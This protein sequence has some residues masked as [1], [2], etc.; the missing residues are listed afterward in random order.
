[1]LNSEK[2]SRRMLLSVAV[3]AASALLV[4][5]A[6]HAGS[7]PQKAVG[8][9]TSPNDGKQCSLCK[10]FIAGDKPDGPGT[11]KSVAGEIVPNGWCKL[12]AAKDA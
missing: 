5:D 3:G 6:A 8:Y 12:F 2:P 10:L 9:Q 1:M 11:C 4:A 7:I